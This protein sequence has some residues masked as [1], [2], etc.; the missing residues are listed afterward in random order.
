[1]LITPL[2]ADGWLQQA[3]MDVARIRLFRA[4]GEVDRLSRFRAYVPYTADRTPIYVHDKLTIVDDEIIRIGSA[5][6]NNRSMGLDSECDVFIDA[7]RP[8]N[9]HAVPAIRRIRLSLLAEHCGIEA[10]EAEELIER[11][12]SMARMI[13]S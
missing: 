4:L 12:G 9:G 8:G 3:T 13:D 5:N 10:S 6:M 1:L 11:H 7:A 2:M